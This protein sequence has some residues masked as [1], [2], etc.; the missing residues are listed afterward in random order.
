MHDSFGWA[1][2][3]SSKT[4]L[5]RITRITSIELVNRSQVQ[6]LESQIAMS[7]IKM[8]NIVKVMT[9]FGTAIRLAFPHTLT[10]LMARCKRLW[11]V[12]ERCG[13][14][15]ARDR[16]ESEAAV[17]ASHSRGSCKAQQ[18]SHKS[19]RAICCDSV[20]SGK[21]IIARIPSGCQRQLQTRRQ[22]TQIGLVPC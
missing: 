9:D 18:P 14:P 11:T 10:V 17:V 22:K 8:T 16:S 2:D 13:G 21:M 7:E 3:T 19:A 1:D 5:S 12:S 15:A 4:F 20:A 6:W